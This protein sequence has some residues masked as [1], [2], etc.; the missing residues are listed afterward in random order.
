MN[1][2]LNEDLRPVPPQQ[3]ERSIEHLLARLWHVQASVC[4]CM[5][6][7]VRAG[8]RACECARLRRRV[9]VGG[10]VVT[11]ASAPSTSIFSA[12]TVSLSAISCSQTATESRCRCGS[13]GPNSGADVA[14][15]APVPEQMWQEQAQSRRRCGRGRPSP[16]A[17]VA[18][19]GPVPE[20]MWH[21]AKVECCPSFDTR[22]TLRVRLAPE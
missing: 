12:S 21:P 4:V 10:M 11:S 22:C 16:G 2:H 15:V 7:R 18:G 9:F 19:A 20:Q 13:G 14:A 5:R 6:G 3:S 8:V 1:V 17:D